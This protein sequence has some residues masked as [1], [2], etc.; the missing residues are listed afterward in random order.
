MKR[1]LVLLL[2]VGLLTSGCSGFAGLND[3]PLPGG[4]DL[5]SHPIHVD[6]QLADTLNLAR[7]ASVKVDD[8]TVGKVTSIDLNGWHPQVHV[9]VNGDV[10]LPAN[11]VAAVRQT[12]LL[13]EKYVE[14]TT[15][16]DEAPQGALTDGAVI[17]V[18][19]TTRSIEVEEVLGA[20]SLLLNGGGIERLHTIASELHQALHGH[21]DDA[22]G[23]LTELDQLTGTLARNRSQIARALDGLDRLTTRLRDGH[24][25]IAEALD[26]IGPALTVLADQRKSLVR[27][28]RATTRFAQVG[29]STVLATRA[30]LLASLHA[31]A[32]TLGRLADAGD[33]LPKALEYMLSF[34]FPDAI[35]SAIHGDYVNSHIEVDLSLSKLKALQ[36]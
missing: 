10:H 25:T 28:L 22:R 9:V 6:I 1:L 15:P 17:A 20:L 14:L 21:E 4:P 35:L 23:L 13:G 8:V 24:R 26:R 7:Q 16:T 19:H 27:M 30:D 2:A 5:G 31:L 12:G 3:V 33:N 18:S 29:T 32:P 36:Q 11:A 34:P